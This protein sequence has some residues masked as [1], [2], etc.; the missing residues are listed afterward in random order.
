MNRIKNSCVG[1]YSKSK[2][3]EAIKC[4][5]VSTWMGRRVSLMQTLLIPAID[6]DQNS[7][8]KKATQ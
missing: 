2:L 3:N 1:I 4:I 7:V 5:V 6:W 8:K